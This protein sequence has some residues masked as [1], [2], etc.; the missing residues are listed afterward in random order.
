[1]TTRVAPK[2]AD[3]A[4]PPLP[5][6]FESSWLVPATAFDYDASIRIGPRPGFLVAI[7]WISLVNVLASLVASI[8][9]LAHCFGAFEYPRPAGD[10]KSPARRS[11]ACILRTLAKSDFSARFPV[12]IALFE[13]LFA[14]THA[15]D[16]LLILATDRFPSKSTCVAIS[17]AKG[18]LFGS[19]QYFAA[20]LALFTYLKV[21]KGMSISL[22]TWDWMLHANTACSFAVI[23]FSVLFTGGFGTNGITCS[24]NTH[25]PA[26]I[27]LLFISAAT[28]TF[29]ACASLFSYTKIAYEVRATLALLSEAMRSPLASMN[30][31]GGTV[32]K[33][34]D[35]HQLILQ[36][37]SNLLVATVVS[38]APNALGTWCAAGWALAGYVEPVSA[39]FYIVPPSASGWANAL[40]YFAN[41]RLRARAAAAREVETDA[42]STVVAPFGNLI[43]PAS[44]KLGSSPGGER[45]DVILASGA[46]AAHPR[47]GIVEMVNLSTTRASLAAAGPSDTAL[48]TLPA[49]ATEPSLWLIPAGDVQYDGTILTGPR[50]W[51]LLAI[52]WIS[53]FNSLMSLVASGLVFAHC[54]GVFEYPA[55]AR[56]SATKE[57]KKRRSC[58]SLLRTLAKS[59]FSARFP[60]YIAIV[61]SWFASTHALDH[62]LLLATLRFPS[63]SECIAIASV[64]A[65][66]YGYAQ[67]YAGFLALFTYLKVVKGK[68]IALG[69]WDWKLH[70]NTA[71]SFAVLY[72]AELFT[73]GL[74]TSG[75]TCSVNLHTTAG[76][77]LFC[78]SAATATFNACASWFSYTKIAHEV[79]AT[80]ALLQS[81][82]RSPLGVPSQASTATTTLTAQTP[83]M[84]TEHQVILKSLSNLLVATVVSSAPNAIGTWVAAGWAITGYVEP[85]ST[86]F[87]LVPPGSSGWANA[88]S[89]FA[90]VRLRAR[91]AEEEQAPPSWAQ[92][93]PG[94]AGGDEKARAG[95]ARSDVA[96]ATGA[97]DSVGGAL[98]LFGAL[99]ALIATS[100][101]ADQ[102]VMDPFAAARDPDASMAMAAT[103]TRAAS[104]TGFPLTV[105]VTILC[106]IAATAMLLNAVVLSVGIKAKLYRTSANLL[107][108]SLAASDL[109]FVSHNLIV[110][111]L[112]GSSGDASYLDRSPILCQVN[113]ALNQISV[114]SGMLTIM[115]IAVERYVRVV[116]T[117]DLRHRAISGMVA[118]AWF[119][120]VGLAMLPLIAGLAADVV[121]W[122]THRPLSLMYVRQPCGTYCM[123]AWASPLPFDAGLKVL[124]GIV[125]NGAAVAL[126]LAYWRI[127][128]TYHA[129][130][131]NMAA[132]RTARRVS[133]KPTISTGNS[134]KHGPLLAK[135]LA[136]APAGA[137]L[138]E[139][140]QAGE[141]PKEPSSASASGGSTR[142]SSNGAAAAE[143]TG[144]ASDN[145][146]SSTPGSS[147]SARHLL[148]SILSGGSSFGGKGA[149]DTIVASNSLPPPPATPANSGV[150]SSSWLKSAR[151]ADVS[152]S[153]TAAALGRVLRGRGHRDSVRIGGESRRMASMLLKRAVAIVASYFVSWVLYDIELF[154]TW[155]RLEP[156]PP[157][158]DAASGVLASLICVWNP[159][160]SLVLDA[161]FRQWVG[162]KK[163]G[164]GPGTGYQGRP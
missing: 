100:D 126:L 11:C 66:S 9:V 91:A 21:V 147:H 101:G 3:T 127:L 152:L 82:M 16:H 94:A 4:F 102:I 142:A 93:M 145:S 123:I 87:Y 17:G 77:V 114:V 130:Q 60:I 156:V 119:S 146:K 54:F 164:G 31:H 47:T 28:A 75:I 10:G 65:L 72:L 140:V 1:M 106:V 149:N 48:R 19:A 12:Y 135:L 137:S 117:M 57:P 44:G 6:L 85:V 89:Y 99:R 58:S 107:I 125:L 83:R 133:K 53:L 71:G 69:Q 98:V 26:G 14:A 160:L 112:V 81:A 25:N 113:G 67:F 34:M 141:L 5:A 109:L 143:S 108:M 148:A 157:A 129:T 35:E 2:T 29:N 120:G 24:V 104:A 132:L 88:L 163:K 20:F 43:A 96:L 62:G 52:H 138:D 110:A 63:E 134:A 86:F 45:K 111:L 131:K 22:G 103:A 42:G 97:L 46:L 40:S 161:R 162:K 76:L 78:I 144:K 36:S 84:S 59:D 18:V 95:R 159:L 74:G 92:G 158:M 61:D 13:T 124:Y 32:A 8:L 118:C 68:Q 49:R 70:L 37:L 90:N 151:P 55:R 122:T 121:G 39:F 27:A 105:M 73:N 154:Y 30:Q 33:P 15:F 50:P 56:N 80:V 136:S 139:S 23:F 41:V 7:H 116:Y 153:G 51:F 79:A 64:K 128:A 38:S 155:A 150:R 115:L